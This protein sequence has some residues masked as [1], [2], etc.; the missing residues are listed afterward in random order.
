MHNARCTNPVSV[1]V[2]NVRWCHT[3]AQ[4]YGL[5]GTG[6]KFVVYG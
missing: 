4:D 1:Q 6:L 2:C 3:L 5:G